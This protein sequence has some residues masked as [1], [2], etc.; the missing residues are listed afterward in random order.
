MPR[1]PIIVTL[2]DNKQHLVL[3][4]EITGCGQVVPQGLDWETE[5]TRRCTTCF[6]GGKVEDVASESE[7]ALIDEQQEAATKPA[8]KATKTK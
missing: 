4:G 2:A 8:R 6:P 7:S 3:D 5:T 1:T